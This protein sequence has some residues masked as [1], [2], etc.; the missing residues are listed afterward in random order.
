M[1]KSPYIHVIS[2]ASL[3]PAHTHHLPLYHDHQLFLPT[4]FK[5]YSVVILGKT[6]FSWKLSQL[7]IFY[8]CSTFLPNNPVYPIQMN[9]RATFFSHRAIVSLNV[10]WQDFHTYRLQRLDSNRL[11]LIVND[12]W[13]YILV[14]QATETQKAPRYTT[15]Q[16]LE[17]LDFM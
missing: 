9:D 2:T 3:P 12:T 7:L 1:W 17:R 15:G 13:L 8:V 6:G 16:S 10:A 11:L 14:Y 5:T 4:K